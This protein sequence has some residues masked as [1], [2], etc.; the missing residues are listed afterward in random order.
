[1][2]IAGHIQSL[3]TSSRWKCSPQSGEAV[4]RMNEARTN[5]SVERISVS[6]TRIYPLIQV[7]YRDLF[8]NVLTLDGFLKEFKL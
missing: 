8:N 2:A 7:F 3:I 6:D 1:M 4:K 5:E